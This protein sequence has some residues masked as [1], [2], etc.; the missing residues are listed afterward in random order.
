[1]AN[2][3][4]ACATIL[5]V[6]DDDDIRACLQEALEDEGYATAAAAN[7]REAL[8]QLESVKRPCLILLD[9][10]M[11]IMGGREF[12]AQLRADDRLAPIP[13]VIVSAWPTEARATPGAQ[14]FIRKPID[15]T[16]LLDVVGGYCA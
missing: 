13:V 14:G 1:M 8:A 11:P 4:R 7:G 16:M 6:E 5:I 3:E 10:M 9:L 15:L 12:L 2:G